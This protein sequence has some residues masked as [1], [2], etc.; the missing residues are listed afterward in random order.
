MSEKEFQAQVVK[1]AR[2][3]GFLVYHTYDSGRS[4]PG[5][6]DLVLVGRGRV[7]Y[8][9]LKTEKG[10]ASAAQVGWLRALRANGADAKVWRPS[11]WPEIE[12]TL[13]RRAA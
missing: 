8:R 3:C 2:T 10:K 6:P 5:W 9:E 1:L 11:D 7:L 12:E 13:A 4:E